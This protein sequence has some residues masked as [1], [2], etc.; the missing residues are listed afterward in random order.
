[1]SQEFQT[2]L[3][4]FILSDDDLGESDKSIMQ[5]ELLHFACLLQSFT[6]SSIRSISEEAA[7]I[8]AAAMVAELESI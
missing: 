7:E 3:V 2:L 5:H 4:F 1:M 6:I 8:L